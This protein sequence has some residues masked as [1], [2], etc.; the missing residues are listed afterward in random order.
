MKEKDIHR[1]KAIHRNG[2][3]ALSPLAVMALLFIALS[4]L[5]HGFH[6][7]PLLVVFILTSV[8]AL[9]TL[10]GMSFEDRLSVFSE[11]AGNKNL[12][13][14]IWI[15]VL[16]G[17]FAATAKA[18]GAVDSTVA[19]TLGLVPPGMLLSGLFVAS[20]FISL[21]I[22][23]SVGTVVAL[24]PIASGLASQAGME[25]P[26]TVAAVVGGSFFGDNL[27]FISDTTVVATRT[28]GC[29]MSDKFR[30]NIRIALPAALVTFLLYALIGS[31]NS[32]PAAPENAA[33]WKIIPYLIVLIT[34]IMG[35]NVLWSLS[36]GIVL[37]GMVG[38]CDGSYTA[39]GFLD[40][41]CTGI[42]GMSELILIS[43]MAGGLLAVIRKGGGITWIIRTLT[44][45]VRSARGAE[46][47]IAAL[48]CL[49]NLCTA[50]NTVAILSV[51][52][53]S[54]DI[55]RKFGVDPRKTASILDTFSC[56]IQ[57][58]IPYGAQLLMAGGLAA[59]PS[60]AI[61][62]YLFY[63]LLLAFCALMAIIFRY[64][65]LTTQP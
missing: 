49:T 64:P 9:L 40:A 36:L 62:P 63:P 29:R 51:G 56:C 32:M 54:N 26:L 61:M 59:I 2:L 20:C 50:N 44:H 8:Y 52:S 53:I 42:G 10:R 11:G 41:I 21:S 25:L 65:R 24:T 55:S 3:L 35:L 37:C 38:L 47:C 16:A 1:H 17:A 48:V 7:V 18:M 27:S 30:V 43:M 58:I 23:T 57:G 31:G 15:F 45:G 6:K 33:W 14:M 39:G 28:Q 13:L 19:L 12:L 34:A 4:F 5:M 60:T 46:G 22:G